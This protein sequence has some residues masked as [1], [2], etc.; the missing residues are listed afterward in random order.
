[1]FFDTQVQELKYKA[2]KEVATLAWQDNLAKGLLGAAA[3]L[4]HNALSVPF[5]QL[6]L[7]L[8]FLPSP[9]LGVGAVHRD[10]DG[11]PIRE[12][13]HIDGPFHQLFCGGLPVFTPVRIPGDQVF[14]VLIQPFQIQDPVSA[15]DGHLHIRVDLDAQGAVGGEI[16]PVVPKEHQAEAGGKARQAGQGLP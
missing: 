4:D 9:P 11:V 14:A 2:L 12:I 3:Q 16:W 15:A 8:N 1:M 7:D 10:G 13:T 5:L 6:G